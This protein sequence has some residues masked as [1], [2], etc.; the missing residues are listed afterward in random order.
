MGYVRKVSQNMKGLSVT[1]PGDSDWDDN[2][3]DPL[4]GVVT[5][6]N[7]EFNWLCVTW[8]GPTGGPLNY[9]CEKF[10]TCV[11]EAESGGFDV[12]LI[13]HLD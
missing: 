5:N 6:I 8:E 11:T 2:G 9:E 1:L 7:T 4:H 13:L 3:F 10:E 12:S